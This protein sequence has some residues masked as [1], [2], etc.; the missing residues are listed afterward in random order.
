M[1]GLESGPDKI[2]ARE[3]DS[4]LIQFLCLLS[5]TS[6]PI[7]RHNRVAM[8]ASR[9]GHL[10]FPSTGQ[11]IRTALHPLFT[12]TRYQSTS[13][14]SASSRPLKLAIIGAGPSGF[15][16]AWRVLSSVP[17]DSPAGRNV[18]VHMYER[19][20]TPYGLVRYGVA[21]DHPEVKVSLGL[22]VIYRAPVCAHIG[23]AMIQE[24]R[25]RSGDA[26]PHR[27]AKASSMSS[28]LTRGSAF[29]AT[30]SSGPHPRLIPLVQPRP[31]PSH[32][33]PT[34][35][36][37]MSPSPRFSH[38][39]PLSSLPTAHPCPTLSPPSRAPRP[40]PIPSSTCSPHWP[41]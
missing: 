27:T 28:R 1:P 22:G 32:R 31:Q 8:R 41:L 37:S 30:P 11:R 9:L 16:A 24:A 6:S 34:L 20:P 26:D 19:L 7:P 39:T 3:T 33:T 5:F 12:S 40:L 10:P 13:T 21:P 17:L 2:T 14:S 15:Y 38:I 25:G 36:P 4:T 29:S 35:T 18:E 23:Q